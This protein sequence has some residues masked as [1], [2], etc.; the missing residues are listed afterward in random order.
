MRARISEPPQPFKH[1]YK[2]CAKTSA[3][4]YDTA[5]CPVIRIFVLL[6]WHLYVHSEKSRDRR[7][8][9]EGDSYHCEGFHDMIQPHLLLVEARVDHGLVKLID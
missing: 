8:W 7:E 9:K 6:P 3:E 1:A 4:Y 5:K 2:E